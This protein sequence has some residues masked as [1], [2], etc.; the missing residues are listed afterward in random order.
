MSHGLSPHNEQYLE[1]VVSA[2]RFPSVEAAID[3][4]VEA[5]RERDQGVEYVPDEHAALV[6]EAFEASAAGNS[7]PMTSEDW[8]S[9]HRLVDE[10]AAR[11]A[12]GGHALSTTN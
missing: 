2:G 9:L 7:R 11:K 8:A 12:K 1:Q 6:D 10:I 5:L 3:A 4:A